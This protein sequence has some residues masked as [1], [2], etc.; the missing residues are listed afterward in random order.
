[1]RCYCRYQYGV[2]K[3][4]KTLSKK[5]AS[6]S[7]NW[8]TIIFIC[9]KFIK[10]ARDSKTFSISMTKQEASYQAENGDLNEKEFPFSWKENIMELN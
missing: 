7:D 3:L 4:K 8:S 2:S 10:F 5:Y 1:M 6:F 9:W